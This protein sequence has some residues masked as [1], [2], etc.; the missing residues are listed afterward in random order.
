MF[1]KNSFAYVDLAD[2][3][4]F[5][6]ATALTG[7]ELKGNELKIEKAASR[8]RKDAGT[9]KGAGGNMSKFHKTRVCIAIS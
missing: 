8:Q 2:P 9:P 3:D 5:E 1:F 7:E 6:K 4:D